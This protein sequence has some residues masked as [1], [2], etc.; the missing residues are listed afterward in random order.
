[1]RISE[2]AKELGFS[3]DHL[4]EL[5]KAGRIPRVTRDANGHRRFKVEEVERLRTILYQQKPGS[6][7]GEQH[8]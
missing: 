5:E 2:V 3:A 4:R 7:R 8:A 6:P 1:M